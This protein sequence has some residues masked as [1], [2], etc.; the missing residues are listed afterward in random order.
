M[1]VFFDAMILVRRSLVVGSMFVRKGVILV[2]A[3]SVLYKGREHV[4]VVKGSMKECLVMLLCRFVGLHAIKC[5][6]VDIIGAMNDA[7]VDSVLRLVGLLLG[8]VVAVV[9]SRKM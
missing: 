1:I 2:C 9:A 6:R 5:Y 8:S 4:L 7:T 3:V